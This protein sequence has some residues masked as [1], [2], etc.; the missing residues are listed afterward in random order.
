MENSGKTI[1]QIIETFELNFCF[2]NFL[3][4]FRFAGN[5]NI[6]KFHVYFLLKLR[7]KQRTNQGTHFEQDLT[8]FSLFLEELLGAFFSY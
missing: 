7:N 2:I 6:L 3:K 4:S 5:V 8:I 1:L